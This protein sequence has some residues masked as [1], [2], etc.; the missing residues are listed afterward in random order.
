MYL[1]RIGI[2]IDGSAVY[3][4]EHSSRQ[5]C[6]DDR[7]SKLVTF[8][9]KNIRCLGSS[10][11]ELAGQQVV[12]AV[13]RV[14]RVHILW[15]GEAKGCLLRGF[16]VITLMA[17]PWRTD[18]SKARAGHTRASGRDRSEYTLPRA[19]EGVSELK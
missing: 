18:R 14:D 6:S 2:A 19:A 16:P 15:K 12:Y 9:V 4:Y 8:T 13:M 10:G 3:T 17:I 11:K 5:V 7:C 1:R